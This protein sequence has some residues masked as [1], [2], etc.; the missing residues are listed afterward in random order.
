MNSNASR[1]RGTEI[2]LCVLVYLLVH[3]LSARYQSPITYN[4]GQ[5]WDGLHYYNMAAQFASGTP[6]QEELPFCNRLGA[7][8]L[9]AA[10][11][12]HDVIAGFNIINHTANALTLVLFAFWLRLFISNWKIRTLLLAL[13]LT[14]WLGPFRAAF[15]YPC[16][17]DF[18]FYPLFLSGLLCI[19]WARSRPVAASLC[20][21]TIV[22]IGVAFREVLF[23]LA[24]GFLFVD[25][26]ISFPGLIKNC[27]RLDFRKVLKLPRPIY[28]LPA[29]LG[30]CSFI[31][32]HKNIHPIPSTYSFVG[33][34]WDSLWKKP[35]FT[36]LHGAFIAFGPILVVALFNWKRAWK[37]LTTHQSLLVIASG[38]YT[39]AY[40][41]GSDTERFWYWSMPITYVLI[42]QAIQDQWH[43]LQSK[44]LLCLLII[45][46]AIS[47]R[48]FWTAPDFP[49][50]IPTPLPILT[51]PSS[52]FQYLDLFSDH[53]RRPIEFVSFIE[54]LLVT[55]I[56]LW[57]LAS[58]STRLN[59]AQPQAPVQTAVPTSI[60]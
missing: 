18:A 21:G 30:L 53:A 38:C 52:H 36:I 41:G 17:T 23:L 22:L 15:F 4:H 57:W 46:Q 8:Y 60:S 6:I 16:S 55:A 12:G 35:W 54:Y 7:P 47:Q 11:K 34:I 13:L 10:L 37:F 19:Q 50:D 45:T 5:G 43:A 29:L 1:F 58:R 24:I 2:L 42:G 28:F 40:I 51:L 14:Q 33:A 48:L 31:L 56:I 39:L 44:G 26:P 27:I 25:N 9:A 20:L 59:P 32:I 49:N 3:T